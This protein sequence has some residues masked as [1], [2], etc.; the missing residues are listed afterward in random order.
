MP[1]GG[2][3]WAASRKKVRNMEKKSNIGVL[4]LLAAGVL[5]SLAG[6]CAKYIP[7]NPLSISCIRGL[8]A[9]AAIGCIRRK[10]TVTLTRSTVAAALCMNV[11]FILFMSAN[12]LTTAANAIVLQYTAPVYVILLTALVLKVK[13]KPVDLV[14]VVLIITGI[15][16][17]FV[18]HLGHGALLGDCL[19]LLSG[20][21]F[22]GVF[23][24]NGLPDAHPQ[25]ASYLGCLL[26]GLLL[27]VLFFDKSLITEG[28]LPWLVILF[29]GVFQ[30]GLAYYLFA[31]GV[32]HTS[33]ITAS[34]I[35]SVEPILNPIWV[36][37][38]MGERPGPLAILG[39]GVVI[40]TVGAYNVLLEKSKV[41]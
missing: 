15:V 1:S 31:K 29:M 27:P 14:A 8:V 34:L 23:F 11:T 6:V 30:L 10:W 5:W 19:G 17:F 25:E 13:P 39:A 20:V 38:L 3:F 7:W 33:S 32:Q 37:L 22:A 40:V 16:L 41:Q 18:D 24:F 28:A 26:S 36:F 35:C 21:S 9:A 2:F 4:C 12:K